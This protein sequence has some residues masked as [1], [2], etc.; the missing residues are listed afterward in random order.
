MKKIITSFIVAAT[1]LTFSFGQNTISANPTDNWIAYM[2][3]FDLPAA[4]G[5]Y[6]FGSPWALADVKSTLDFASGTIILQPNFNTYQAN[7][8]DPFWVDQTTLEGNKQME[9]L[10]FVEPGAIFNGSNL[11][12]SGNVVSSTLASGYTA[13][14]FIKALDPA[15]G[16]A[17]A[18]VGAKVFDLPA[19]GFF[20]VNATGAELS[21]GLIIQYGFVISGPNAN[22]ADEAA[23]GSVTIGA[24][25]LNVGEANALGSLTI[26]PNPSSDFLSISSEIAIE[27][28][29]VF[30]TTGQ[31]LMNESYAG[32]ID[33]T[34]LQN[35][36]YFVEIMS[37]D[38]KEMRSF[39]KK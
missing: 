12:F 26:Y 16:Y 5:G 24:A 27:S 9:A 17:D 19:S 25:D 22:P 30:S 7:P 38:L 13:Q 1:A 15:N 8:T 35:G 32:S 39:V 14:F 11:T 28:Y 23:L 6:Q 36:T 37:G 3:V 33:L 2:N 29:K 31:L 34:S 10:T 20:T 18:L 21:T 4:G